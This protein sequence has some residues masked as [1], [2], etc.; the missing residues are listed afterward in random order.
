MPLAEDDVD[1]GD[2]R[3]VSSCSSS[4]PAR[5]AVMSKVLD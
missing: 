2:E 4:A 1:R 5:I 3:E